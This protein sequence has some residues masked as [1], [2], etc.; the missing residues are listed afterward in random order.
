[1]G[2]H[3]I[4]EAKPILVFVS[5]ITFVYL[6]CYITYVY[7][8]LTDMKNPSGVA[9]GFYITFLFVLFLPLSFSSFSKI[10][11][12]RTFT[13]AV[14]LKMFASPYTGVDYCSNWLSEQM[15]SFKLAFQDISEAILFFIFG[16]TECNKDIAKFMGAIFGTSM[17]LLRICQASKK[18]YAHPHISIGLPPFR[19]ILKCTLGIAT[20]WCSFVYGYYK[21]IKD[22]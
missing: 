12:G 17:F 5:F 15:T 10:A 3:A 22:K 13:Q 7:G 9:F 16:P 14:I 18:L 19:G 21:Q 2:S 1:M 4:P 8:L 20:I 6:L 11:S